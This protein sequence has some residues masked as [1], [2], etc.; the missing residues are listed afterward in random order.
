MITR[1]TVLLTSSRTV[2]GTLE[3]GEHRL[4]DA[5]NSSLTSVLHVTSAT[6][7]RL[8]NPQANEPVS[9]AVVP[10]AQAALILV[11]DELRRPEEKRLN[12]YASKRTSELLV[13][14]SGLRLRGQAHV[15]AHLDPLELQ[16][17]LAAGGD[18]FVVL[19]DAWLALDVEGET[20]RHVGLAMLNARH[21]Q[22]V[23]ALSAEPTAGQRVRRDPVAA[24]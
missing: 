6:L 2:T 21:I 24:R 18:R 13:L 15:G 20:E 19:T 1:V 3:H 9:V 23:A 7:G 17:Q 16:R 14:I 22:F 11:Q 5:L 12:P 8:G 10:K 4:S